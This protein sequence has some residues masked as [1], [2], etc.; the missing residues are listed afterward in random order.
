MLLISIPLFLSSDNFSW[1]IL[2]L[3]TSDF[4]CLSYK[5]TMELFSL[6]CLYFSSFLFLSCRYWY[7]ILCKILSLLENFNNLY[8]SDVDIERFCSSVFM[9]SA[10]LRSPRSPSI[11]WMYSLSVSLC[12]LHILFIVIIFRVFL[13][14]TISSSFA[15]FSTSALYLTK[16]TAQALIDLIVFPTF[17]LHDIT[18]LTPLSYTCLIF[19]CSVHYVITSKIP[20]Y[21]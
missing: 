17:N 14:V 12:G 11:L 13:S 6:H 9:Q 21:L 10:M 19:H 5:F 4:F 15:H 2:C 7:F 16:D 1:S 8:Q 18:C 3:L 20:K